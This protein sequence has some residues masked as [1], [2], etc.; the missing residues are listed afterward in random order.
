MCV[1]SA[2]TVL[3]GA[4]DNGGRRAIRHRFVVAACGKASRVVKVHLESFP[5]TKIETGLLD[6]NRFKGR[7]KT[8]VLIEK[9]ATH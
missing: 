9:I 7:I 6:A 4:G 3:R 8:L 1:N 2:S 5:S